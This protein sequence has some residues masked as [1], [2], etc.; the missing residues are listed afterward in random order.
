MGTSIFTCTTPSIVAGNITSSFA[1]TI[2]SS[3]AV[4]ITGTCA[5]TKHQN[6]GVPWGKCA[7]GVA[8]WSVQQK[9]RS[10]FSFEPGDVN[11]VETGPNRANKQ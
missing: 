8:I 5:V 9:V 3:R 1:A 10:F 6:W 7:F 4:K 11:Q 2:P